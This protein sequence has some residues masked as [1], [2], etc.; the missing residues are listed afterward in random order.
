[1]KTAQQLVADAKAHIKEMSIDELEAKLEANSESLVIDVREPA[2]F[3]GGHIPHAVN[4]PRGILEFQLASL[5]Q[6]ASAG[7]APEIAL[8]QIRSNPVYL[9]CRT[10]GRSALA[11]Y[12][13]QQMG[14]E[15]VY[16]VAGGMT[17]WDAAGKAMKK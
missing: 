16:S 11:A 2:E 17:A 15:Q 14:F 1:M 6:V 4:L 7:C 9:I 8:E 5:P 10:G 12:S 13:L 3:S